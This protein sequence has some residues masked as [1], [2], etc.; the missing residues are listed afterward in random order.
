MQSLILTK[1]SPKT[2]NN[3][4]KIKT[5]CAAPKKRQKDGKKHNPWY[6]NAYKNTIY[7]VFGVEKAG[8]DETK[9]LLERKKPGQSKIAYT[10]LC[11]LNTSRVSKYPQAT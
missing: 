8:C 3:P 7:C 2:Q 10:N 5:R 11:N 1:N 9:G 6:K 4:G